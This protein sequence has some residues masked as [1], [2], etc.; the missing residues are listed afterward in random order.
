MKNS[1]YCVINPDYRE[2]N[3]LKLSPFINRMTEKD[4]FSEEKKKKY[5]CI[6]SVL[7]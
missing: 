6:N 7:I 4:L 2:Q 3:Q 1:F 5:I